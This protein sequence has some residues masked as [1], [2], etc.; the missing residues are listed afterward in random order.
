M[1]VA[2][3]PALDPKTY[4]A[5]ALHTDERSWAE[6]NCYVDLWIEVLHAYGMEPLACMA[7]TVAINYR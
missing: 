3:S 4:V 5:H 2:I 1:K 7:F 6:T